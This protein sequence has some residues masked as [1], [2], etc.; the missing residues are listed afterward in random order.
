[1]TSIDSFRFNFLIKS[2]RKPIH[3][4]FLYQPLSNITHINLPWLSITLHLISN[5]YIR[6]INI[7][8]HNMRSSNPSNNLSSMQSNPHIQITSMS[9]IKIPNNLN[10]T[11]SHLKHIHTFLNLISKSIIFI[12][13]HNI[14][15]SNSMYFI[16][17]VIN[18]LLIKLSKHLTKHYHNFSRRFISRPGCKTDYISIQQ[19]Y[20]H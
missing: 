5:Q 14:T 20:I 10:H 9:F 13:H 8:P 3:I 4:L 19:S 2:K 12:P 7:I 15:I 17:L 6:S 18:T 16:N 1:M 11:P